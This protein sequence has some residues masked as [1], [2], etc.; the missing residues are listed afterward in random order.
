M[1]QTYFSPATFRFLQALERNN[2]RVWFHAHHA[3][4]ERHVREP[5]L[6]LIADLQSPLE[7]I[8]THFRADVRK[9]GG[10]LYRMHRDTRFSHDKTP[11]KTWASASLFHER[12]REVDAPSFYIRI[13]PKNCS[14]AGGLRQPESATL[15]RLRDFLVEEAPG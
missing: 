6:Q 15:K 12:R 7:K 9:V 13:Q 14:V 8:S 4:Y 10:S 1:T 2:N 11:Y 3:D 5:F